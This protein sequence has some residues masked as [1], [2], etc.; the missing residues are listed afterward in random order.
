M[1]FFTVTVLISTLTSFATRPARVLTS[2]MALPSS[3]TDSLKS[4]A[5]LGI[6]IDDKKETVETQ[7]NEI[8]VSDAISKHAGAHGSLC[9]VVRRPG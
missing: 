5:L 1:K 2:A 6:D 7:E 9:Y 8:K 3:V 4:S